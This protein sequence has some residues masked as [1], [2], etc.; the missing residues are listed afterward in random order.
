MRTI[1]TSVDTTFV[2]TIDQHWLTVTSLDFVA[3]KPY[4][5]DYV[6]RGIC[7]IYSSIPLSQLTGQYG[8]RYHIVVKAQPYKESGPVGML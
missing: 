1:N 2:F 4:K 3:I 5:T 7:W 6:V 8:Q